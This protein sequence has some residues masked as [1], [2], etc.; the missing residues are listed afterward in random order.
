MIKLTQ[1]TPTQ[2]KKR[3]K[4]PTAHGR[5]KTTYER[6][7]K[8]DATREAYATT[9]DKARGDSRRSKYANEVMAEK[10][11]RHERRQNVTK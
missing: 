1:D 7:D 9:K 3:L 6:Q 8:R 10:K 5:R 11:K 2:E 4:S